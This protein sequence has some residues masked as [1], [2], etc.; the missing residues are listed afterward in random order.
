MVAVGADRTIPNIGG[1]RMN[2]VPATRH[3]IT[4]IYEKV[5]LSLG[6]SVVNKE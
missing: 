5:S 4:E 6:A 2:F 3:R 1:H